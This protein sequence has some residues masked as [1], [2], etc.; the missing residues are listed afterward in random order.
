MWL[1]NA[2]VGAGWL[3]RHRTD[4]PSAVLRTSLG[5]TALTRD[6]SR[7]T[8][9]RQWYSP[10]GSVRLTEGTLP[11]DY[12]FTGQKQDGNGLLFYQARYY[13][14]ALGRFV[15]ADS[16]IPD[17]YNPQ[18]LN[19]YAYVLN[20]PV[21][22]ADPSGHR[23]CEDED[24][25][26]RERGAPDK[27]TLPS[28][29]TVDDPKDQSPV[30][31]LER[32]LRVTYL[33]PQDLFP[34][35]DA[36]FDAHPGYHPLLD[37][38]GSRVESY[39]FWWFLT[40]LAAGDQTQV[41]ITPLGGVVLVAGTAIENGRPANDPAGLI[42]YDVGSFDQ[43]KARSKSGDNLDIHHS[44]QKSPA[45]QVI[46]GYKPGAAPAIVLPQTE[47]RA[48]NAANLTGS[49]TGTPRDLAAKTLSDLR[50]YTNA[51]NSALRNL[52]SL[53]RSTYP[54]EFTK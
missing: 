8:L 31:I 27:P 11:T 22:Y 12:T 19:R 40:R 53:M 43:L 33:S 6:S 45:G 16:I 29:H 18:S 39:Y 21:K 47:H 44:P 49:Y 10:Y 41:A 20:N 38:E 52:L 25:C 2:G 42:S 28:M 9:G 23:V 46:R 17:P 48:V 14:A 4:R 30:W 1:T 32:D 26:D 15:Q 50:N 24:N 3:A 13:D 51:P 36:W 37:P 5:S 35:M 54:G 34:E 7:G